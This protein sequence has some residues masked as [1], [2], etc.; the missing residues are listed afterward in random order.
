MVT[1]QNNLHLKKEKE[2]RKKIRKTFKKFSFRMYE[3]RSQ[4]NAFYFFSIETI[5]DTN[6]TITPL[7]GAGFQ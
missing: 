3:G 1:E 2:D 6:S 7:Y 5:K 4:S